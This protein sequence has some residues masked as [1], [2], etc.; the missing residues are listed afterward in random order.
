MIES[1]PKSNIF[2]NSLNR[3]K[4]NYHLK[5]VTLCIYMCMYVFWIQLRIVWATFDNL[6]L[7]QIWLILRSKDLIFCKEDPT[8]PL[9]TSTVVK[10]LWF[11]WRP[12][13]NYVFKFPIYM[14]NLLFTRDKIINLIYIKTS[15][16]WLNVYFLYKYEYI[17]FNNVQ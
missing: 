12:N 3:P 16:H 13:L 10:N 14:K 5:Y 7:F 11:L 1:I 2:W 8:L 6:K 9:I 17:L 15:P 4:K